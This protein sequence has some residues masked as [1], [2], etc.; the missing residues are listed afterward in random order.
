MSPGKWQDQCLLS[1]WSEEYHPNPAVK[2][3]IKLGLV[4]PKRSIQGLYLFLQCYLNS[5]AAVNKSQVKG[6]PS[7]LHHS[8]R[9]FARK[10]SVINQL[11]H[12]R[13]GK[14]SVLPVMAGKERERNEELD[15]PD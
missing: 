4:S 10:A 7:A 11:S 5:S 12:G 13:G 15:L 1:V 3:G 8:F 2:R 6:T 14:F 9:I